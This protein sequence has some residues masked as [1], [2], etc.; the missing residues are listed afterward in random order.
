MA[1]NRPCVRLAQ[2]PNSV[3]YRASAAA[4][5]VRGT[6]KVG[7]GPHRPIKMWRSR[8]RQASP[9]L[10]GLEIECTTEDSQLRP[11]STVAS[12]FPVYVRRCC[13]KW[14]RCGEPKYRPQVHWRGHF[15]SYP[16][17]VLG[18]QVVF[19]RGCVWPG[20]LPVPCG[21]LCIY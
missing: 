2:A 5:Q 17:T 18:H 12:K 9:A 4:H 16:V 10:G 1:C 6:N 11:P 14:P 13:A 3:F 7:P 21:P 19:L 8:L 20:F 15:C